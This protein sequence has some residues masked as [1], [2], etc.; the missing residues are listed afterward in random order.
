MVR[1]ALELVPT[2]IDMLGIDI[3]PRHCREVKRL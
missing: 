2:P 3:P 1:V